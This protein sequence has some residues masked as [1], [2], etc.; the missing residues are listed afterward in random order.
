MTKGAMASADGRKTAAEYREK[1]G[2]IRRRAE[3]IS[4]RAY[5][6]QMLQIAAVL[7]RWADRKD[8]TVIRETTRRAAARDGAG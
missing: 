1:A 6:Q 5:R 2:E 8:E 4:N 3:V 7:E